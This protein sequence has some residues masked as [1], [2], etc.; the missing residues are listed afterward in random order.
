MNRNLMIGQSGGCTAVINQSLA[1][2]IRAAQ[3]SA[4]VDK[5]FGLKNGITGVLNRKYIDLTDLGAEDLN[6]L[7]ATPS[8]AL[9]SCRHKIDEKDTEIVLK[10]I[11]RK[12]VGYFLMI[13][14]NDSAMTT[15]RIGEAA[16]KK[17]YDLKVVAVPKTIDNDLPCMDQT[18]GYGSNA[19]FIACATQEA[20]KDTESMK[21][22]DPI[23]IIEVMGRNSGWLVAAA[24]LGKK[25]AK[26]APHLMC[27]PERAFDEKKFMDD[28]KKAYKKYGYCVI[29][30]SETIK[31]K[32]G[33]R[34]GERKDDGVVADSF[35]HK[36]VD[37]AAAI[38]CRKIEQELGVRARYD[39]PGTIS[40]M[41]M[42]Y[43]SKVDQKE[44]FMVGEA[45][46]KFAVK[47]HTRIIVTIERVSNQPYKTKA[48]FVSVEEV[49]GVEKYLP[50]SFINKA[51]N[52]VTKRF[53]DYAA[54]L[55]GEMPD[56]FRF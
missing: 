5:I 42:G 51:G 19:R 24:A 36:Y 15:A 22:V 18:P 52:F 31:D 40:R 11:M 17:G 44:A 33:V 50:D 39:K 45:A 28:V 54:P 6:K 8:A 32:N 37:S 49:S 3:K 29:V 46:V 41:S 14:G 34:L 21:D 47:G 30:I 38:L 48:G 20:G 2:V 26:D 16:E 1:G 27:F 23:K 55:V 56:F 10:E 53:M 43:I 35:G 25:S 13:G 7:K 9:G 12:E 4:K